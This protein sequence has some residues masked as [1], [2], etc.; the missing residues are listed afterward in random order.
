MKKAELL[1]PAGSLEAVQ[2]AIAAGADAVYLGAMAH[3][4]RA[5]VGFDDES[6]K[7]AVHLAH[8]Y[9]R[10]VYVTV[11]TLVKQR[12][13]KAVRALLDKL[14][15]LRVDAVIVQDIGVLR[16]VK[17]IYPELCVHAST[18]MSVHNAAGAALLR[19]LGAS[20]VILARECGLDEI[21]AAA[22]TGIETEVFI[23][24]A[25]CV[26]VSGQCLF[27]SH[28][29]GR[30]GNRGKC[31]QPCRLQYRYG[32]MSGALLSMNDMNTLEYLPLMHQA[33]VRSFKIEG[34][35]KRPEYVSVVTGIYRRALD[36]VEQGLPLDD[37]REDQAA[38]EQIFSRGFTPGYAFSAQDSALISV[39][40]VNHRG[41]LMGKLLSFQQRDGFV[42]AKVRLSL[43]LSN[44]DGLSLRGKTEQ[45]FIYSGPFVPAGREA[46]LRLRQAPG[47]NDVLYKLQ[48]ERQLQAAREAASLLPGIGFNARLSLAPGEPSTL[49]VESGGVSFTVTGDTPQAAINQPLTADAVERQLIKTGGTAFTLN[50]LELSCD[51]PVF[52][53]AAS[54]NALRRQALSGLEAALVTAHRLPEAAPG[55]QTT[56]LHKRK[57]LENTRLYAILPPSLPTAPFTALGVDRVIRCPDNYREGKL[58]EQLSVFAPDDIILLPRQISDADFLEAARVISD[59]GRQIMADN[60]GQL[61]AGYGEIRFAGEGIP[62]WNNLSLSVL[63]SLGVRSAV[64]S[65]EL[66]REEVAQLSGDIIELILPVYGH[67]Q[68]M[69]LNHCPERLA[70]GLSRNKAGCTFCERGQGV[71]NK[72][73]IDRMDAAYPLA[74]T[75]FPDRCLIALHAPK[76]LHLSDSATRMSWL[77]DLRFQDEAGAL[78]VARHYADLRSGRQIEDIGRTEPGRY[79][80]GVE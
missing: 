33:G 15:R 2:A 62:V 4:A 43:P 61:G 37:L 64:V 78:R 7:A 3:G 79:L 38:L 24:G 39:S 72:S 25:M 12:E 73:L 40:S 22:M 80:L 58:K 71:R 34:R 36:K 45:D 67:T 13:L 56:R 20:R 48:D 10:R 6:L 46:T 44:G 77:I 19:D 21:R 63:A 70:R 47:I 60:L 14:V 65:R 55:K 18:Q 52:L 49:K 53:P 69:Q 11:N 31:A 9:G 76:P 16:L 28:I 68:L 30:S 59:S 74:P 42:L 50:R 5:S 35:L 66:S 17:A 23:H 29:G 75:H 41:L 27:S 54:I 1:S 51:A 57:W 32:N 8:L 26:S